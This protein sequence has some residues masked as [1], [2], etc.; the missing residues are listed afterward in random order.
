MGWKDR[1]DDLLLAGGLLTMLHCGTSGP[2]V[3][4]GNANPDP[5]ICGRPE[6]SPQYKAQCDA[7]KAC[8]AS[9]G[10]WN[11]PSLTDPDGDVVGGGCAHAGG[12]TPDA[13]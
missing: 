3:P 9:G 13:G 2:P 6:Q 1:L 4:C 7:L 12:G 10:H 5:C 11:G 8:E